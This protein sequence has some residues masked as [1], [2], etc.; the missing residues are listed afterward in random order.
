MNEENIGKIIV[1]EPNINQYDG[2]DLKVY[3]E[4]IK[5]S[6]ILVILVQH[7]EFVDLYRL[8]SKDQIVIDVCGI[9]RLKHLSKKTKRVCKIV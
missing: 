4:V 7:Q 9:F 8:I 1:A 6:D 2:L 5:Q 3:Q